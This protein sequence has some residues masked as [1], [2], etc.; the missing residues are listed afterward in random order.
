M[1]KKIKL[2]RTHF[3]HRLVEVNAKIIRKSMNKSEVIRA[4]LRS[5][6]LSKASLFKSL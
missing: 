5:R 2:T 1:K 6:S 4:R 3:L